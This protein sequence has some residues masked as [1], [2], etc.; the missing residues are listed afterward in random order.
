MLRS[1]RIALVAN[2]RTAVDDLLYTSDFCQGFH[3]RQMVIHD[4]YCP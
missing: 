3:S 1:S 2:D 4:T